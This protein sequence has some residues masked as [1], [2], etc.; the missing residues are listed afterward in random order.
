M[1]TRCLNQQ[2]TSYKYYGAR[3]ITICDRWAKFENF[4]ADMGVRPTG[5]TIDRIDVNAGYS[6]ENCR[7]VSKAE[8]SQNR[9]KLK[10]VNQDRLLNFL[11]KQSFL[12]EEQATELAYA[13]FKE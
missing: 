13:F 9:R 6:P 11:K 12:T 10:L 8:Q 4:I 2:S 3:G 5:L 7:W 1:K